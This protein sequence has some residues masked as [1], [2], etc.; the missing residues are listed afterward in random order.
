MAGSA[1]RRVTAVAAASLAAVLAA[2]AVLIRDEAAY[3]SVLLLAGAVLGAAAS[4]CL[5]LRGCFTARFTLVLVSA[6]TLLGEGLLVALGL[7][8]LGRAA[9]RTG[10]TATG[11]AA[12]LGAVVV[13]RGLRSQH[14]AGH[15]VG[16]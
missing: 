10:L 13:L 4:V 14:D 12:V 2:Q 11:A 9:A 8:G 3:L 15:R 1:P 7:P 5:R 16:P 6:L